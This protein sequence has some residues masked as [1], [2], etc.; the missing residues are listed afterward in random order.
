MSNGWVRWLLMEELRW[1]TNLSNDTIEK[2]AVGFM[3]RLETKHL[4]IVPT[5][6]SD[7]MYDAQRTAVGHI[8]YKKAN[9]MYRAALEEHGRRTNLPWEKQEE[10]GFW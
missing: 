10:G 7:E 1:R 8:D 3:D 2:I 6:L 4:T 5:Y 9:S